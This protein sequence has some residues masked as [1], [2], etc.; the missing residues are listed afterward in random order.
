MFIIKYLL[1][2]KFL[3]TSYRESNG[4]KMLCPS[5]NEASNIR[6][7]IDELTR[8]FQYNGEN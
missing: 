3:V 2:H 8:F 7:F 1:N 4:I 5:D 6:G